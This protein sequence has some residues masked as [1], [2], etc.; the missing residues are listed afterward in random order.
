MNRT[1]FNNNKRMSRS[2]A[3]ELPYVLFS[4]RPD[5]I[6]DSTHCRFP[7]SRRRMSTTER[8]MQT[9]L[10][11]SLFSRSV[12][13]SADSVKIRP[14]QVFQVLHAKL[15]TYLEYIYYSEIINF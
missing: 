7:Y 2:V 15:Y 10:T 8:H 14:I 9:I 5:S 12:H 4:V 13:P 1:Y 11:A 3:L 6:F